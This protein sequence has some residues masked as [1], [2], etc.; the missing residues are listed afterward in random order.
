M[1]IRSSLLGCR[2]D[3]GQH[4]SRRGE[5]GPLAA[6]LAGI[7]GKVLLPIG[8]TPGVRAMFAAFHSTEANT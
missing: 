8:D 6:P 2:K 5:F 3:Y 4:V 7:N 1:A